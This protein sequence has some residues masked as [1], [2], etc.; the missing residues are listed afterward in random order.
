MDQGFNHEGRLLCVQFSTCPFPRG[1]TSSFLWPQLLHLESEKSHACL[2]EL[3][4]QMQGENQGWCL[5]RRD[6]KTRSIHNKSSAL[7]GG[8]L[9][10]YGKVGTPCMLNLNLHGDFPDSSL[11]MDVSLPLVPVM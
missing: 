9:L 6:T 5:L 11:V 2:T 7:S 4:H 3:L 8:N 1:L 10:D